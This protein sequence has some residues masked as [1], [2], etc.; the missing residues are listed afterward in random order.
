MTNKPF[1]QDMLLIAQLSIL[2]H[3]LHQQEKTLGNL[4]I[5]V[6][7]NQELQRQRQK[8]RAR[9]SLSNPLNEPVHLHTGDEFHQDRLKALEAAQKETH[10][11][12]QLVVQQVSDIRKELCHHLELPTGTEP[13]V[14]RID[15]VLQRNARLIDD[16][17]RQLSS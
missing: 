12:I 11:L 1:L 17:N 13:L 4:G 8:L 5:A 10:E 6:L 14:A 16:R 9:S 7:V 15:E 3:R 2:L